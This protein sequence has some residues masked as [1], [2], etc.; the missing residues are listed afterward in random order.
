MRQGSE[1]SPFYDSMIAKL[2]VH[3]DT[4]EKT[5]KKMK[6]A[7]SAFHI[8]GVSTNIPLQKAIISSQAFAE[9]EVDTTYVE[10]HLKEFLQSAENG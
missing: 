10:R 1:I 5:R 9:G 7:L 4:R 3:D 2:I 8:E 6:E